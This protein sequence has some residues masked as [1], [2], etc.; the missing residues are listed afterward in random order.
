MAGS[1][2]NHAHHGR[3]PV[4]PQC[5]YLDQVV[6]IAY[7]LPSPELIE[8]ARR[9]EVALGGSSLGSGSPEWYCKGCLHKFISRAKASLP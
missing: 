5:G 1:A 7:G 2:A 6:P 8:Q 9:G 3:S 4:C